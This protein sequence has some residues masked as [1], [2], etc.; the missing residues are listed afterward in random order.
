[1]AHVQAIIAG[2]NK[3]FPNGTISFGNTTYTAAALVQ[4][5]QSLADAIAKVNASE[6]S[7]RDTVTALRDVQAKV[8]PVLRDYRRF[9]LATFGTA[10]EALTDFGLT[11]P[12]ARAPLTAEQRVAAT[13]KTRATRTARGTTS[14][15]QKAA[16]KGNVTGV[17]ITPVV[18]PTATTPP[19][20]PAPATSD[21]P[22][23]GTS[24]K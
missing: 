20:Q 18:E 13:A 6:A 5:F 3:R 10:S 16:V 15:K 12:K 7:T 19:A 8:N 1:V 22:K 23:P 4:L 9:I 21:V 17:T 14:K 24:T 2:T 11:P